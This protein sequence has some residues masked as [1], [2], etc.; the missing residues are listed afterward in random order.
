M[1]K[2][3]SEFFTD[4]IFIST[5][6]QVITLQETNH[7]EAMLDIITKYENHISISNIKR[8]NPEV[9]FSFQLTSTNEVE[10]LI[11]EIKT[12]K[13]MRID[14]MPPK[15]LVSLKETISEPVK[16]IINPM[17]S[18]G[19]FPD[20]A[21]T[22][23]ITQ[24]YKKGERTLKTS[25]RPIDILPAVSKQLEKFMFKQMLNYFEKFIRTRKN[26]I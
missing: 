8:K 16:N 12:N 6:K 2:K 9:R 1:A 21:K 24:A 15:I 26:Y 17:V 14:T 20:Q 25:Y 4:I 5:A 18:E 11:K 10:A 22:S 7:E 23:S 13:P 19:C 3:L